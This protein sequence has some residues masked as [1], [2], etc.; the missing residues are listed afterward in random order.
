VALRHILKGEGKIRLAL[1]CDKVF[2]SELFEIEC[3]RVIHRCRME[4]GLDDEGLILALERLEKLLDGMNLISLSTAV[5]KRAM[6]AF[7]VVVKTL[8]ALHLASAIKLGEALHGEKVVVFSHDK[9]INQCAKALG[10]Q[11]PVEAL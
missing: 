7:P 9:A 6:E 10:L 2:S 1:E 11:L 3:R 5:K 4:G 8:D